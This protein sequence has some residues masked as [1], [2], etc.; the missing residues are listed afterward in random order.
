MIKKDR[1]GKGKSRAVDVSSYRQIEHTPWKCFR[2]GSADHMIAKFP[3][4]VYFN[5][6]FNRACDS[7]KN[8]SNC[9]IYASIAQMSSND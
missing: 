7:S 2:C 3:K 5:E 4:Q 9:K 1:K 8:K 6:H